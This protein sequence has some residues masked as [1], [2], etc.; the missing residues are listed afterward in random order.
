LGH[1][2]GISSIAKWIVI[3]SVAI[4]VFLSQAIREDRGTE[5][6]RYPEQGHQAMELGGGLELGEQSVHVGLLFLFC[7]S[8]MRF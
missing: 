2:V 5:H 3:G 1:A 4:T 6:H 8:L 7:A